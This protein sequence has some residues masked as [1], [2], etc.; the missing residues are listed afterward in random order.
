ME[1]ML[2]IILQWTKKRYLKKI[3]QLI[4]SIFYNENA[5]LKFY[6]RSDKNKRWP[7]NCDIFKYDLT[8][9]GRQIVKYLPNLLESLPCEDTIG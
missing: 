2:M 6:N 5:I 3:E 8:Q 7:C 4:D 9:I 1:Y